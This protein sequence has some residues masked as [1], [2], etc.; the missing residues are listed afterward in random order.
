MKVLHIIALLFISLQAYSQ[1]FLTPAPDPVSWDMK[2]AGATI[3]STYR[4]KTDR[5]LATDDVPNISYS[6]W[7]EF[8]NGLEL[9]LDY[10]YFPLEEL[11]RR[12]YNTE[13]LTASLSFTHYIMHEDSAFVFTAIMMGA[14]YTYNAP[15]T[16]QDNYTAYFG[17]A[18]KLWVFSFMPRI[19]YYY[20]PELKAGIN[21]PDQE[22]YTPSMSISADLPLGFYASVGGAWEKDIKLFYDIDPATYQFVVNKET[23]RYWSVNGSISNTQ[24][25][26]DL[27]IKA[28]FYKVWYLKADETRYLNDTSKSLKFTYYAT[29]ERDFYLTLE[30]KQR[31]NKL[32]KDYYTNL[33][34]NILLK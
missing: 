19:S 16:L 9:S 24:T 4:Y 33:A 6:T 26:G 22:K 10:G 1:Q 28:T 5:D 2:E 13:E 25:F 23:G 7:F 32:Y 27:V 29:K 30:V 31:T 34:V 14:S 17:L 21:M 3:S 8:A 11:D 18:S 12:K 15:E 20:V